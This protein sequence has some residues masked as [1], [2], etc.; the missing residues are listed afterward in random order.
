MADA[1]HTSKMNCL[2]FQG[3]WFILKLMVGLSGPYEK[4][5]SSNEIGIKVSRA[6]KMKTFLHSIYCHCYII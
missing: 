3:L 4:S 5:Q 6:M 1:M 2:I